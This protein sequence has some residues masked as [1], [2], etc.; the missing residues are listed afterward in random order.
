MKSLPFPCVSAAFCPSLNEAK[1]GYCIYRVRVK[2]GD[3]KK[4]VAKADLVFSP[5]EG[6]EGF[7]NGVCDGW[8]A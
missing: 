1:Q 3:R 8:M 5:L 4:R 6:G 7:S 2:R